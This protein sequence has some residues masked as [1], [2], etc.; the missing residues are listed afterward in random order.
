VSGSSP[1]RF[2]V[3]G[4]LG[5]IGAWTVRSLVRDGV[6]V[7][8]YD[9]GNDRRRLRLLMTP[10]E[11]D[12]VTFVTGD[13][14]EL[15]QLEAAL[16]EHE[17]NRVIHLAALQVPFC[18]A[19]PP[20]GARVNVVGTVNIFE[21]VKRRADR[22]GPIVYTSSIGIYAAD[23]ADPRTG[24]L[25]STATAHPLNHYGVYK[26]ANEGTARIYALDDGL[27][28]IGLRP[29][30]V[31]GVGRDQG[32]TS[33]PTKAIVAA[34]LG[35]PYTVPFGG[36]TLYQLAED[37][38]RTLILASRTT[39]SGAHVFNLPG[40]PVDRAG[41]VEAIETAVP[42]AAGLLD[43]APVSL[44]FPS[45]IDHDGIEALGEV[46]LTPFAEGVGA[47]VGILRRLAETDRLDPL[48]HGLEVASSRVS[49]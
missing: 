29:M 27:T 44:P 13:I 3:T 48:E 38:A 39:L 45:E 15:D 18:R 41:L 46:P 43:F 34:V 24:R 1:E 42:G 14:T 8:A 5:C 12:R 26:L 47:T 20:L 22:M 49:R 11:L 2:L 21:A 30:T 37:V 32:M 36:A 19:D 40:A 28:S 23:D 7:V 6:P 31:Y 33:G 9:L 35:Q 4:A 17:I 10:D 16:D 25:L